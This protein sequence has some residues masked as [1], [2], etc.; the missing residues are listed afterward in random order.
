MRPGRSIGVAT[1]AM[2][3]D[4]PMIERALA[5]AQL[6][7]FLSEVF[8]YRDLGVKKADPAFWDAVIARAG[9]RREELIMVGDDLEQDVLAP[10]RCGIAAIWFNW[11]QAPGHPGPDVPIIHRLADLPALIR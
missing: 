2:V 8:C 3:S 11:K 9:V 10:R 6:A 7:A 5:R 4:R 1:N